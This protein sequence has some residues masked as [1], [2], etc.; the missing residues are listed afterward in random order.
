MTRRTTTRAKPRRA[1]PRARVPAAV[2]QYLQRTV[3]SNTRIGYAS[4]VRHFLANG[5]KFPATER[6]VALYLARHADTLK[7]ATLGRRL[8][9]LQWAHRERCRWR[10]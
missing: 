9:A 3:A 5:G 4:D 10:T 7:V 1:S 8:A 6:M 2:A